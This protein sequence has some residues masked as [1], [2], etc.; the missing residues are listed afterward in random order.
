M[1]SK[2][3]SLQKFVQQEAE[4]NM[5]RAKCLSTTLKMNAMKQKLIY[6]NMENMELRKELKRIT[7]FSCVAKNEL[8]AIENYL[9]QLERKEFEVCG[10][11]DV[12][13]DY[14]LYEVWQTK[15]SFRPSLNMVLAP[16]QREG[17]RS[18]NGKGGSNKTNCFR[19]NEILKFRSHVASL[20]RKVWGATA[21]K[22]FKVVQE[23][24]IGIKQFFDAMLCIASINETV[25]RVL[26][27]FLGK[28]G[29][30]ETQY[31]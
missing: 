3:A 7:L 26:T 31:M 25:E 24:E 5:L 19:F 2:N 10:N 15:E 18:D 21:S 28:K 14:V 20:P 30:K 11:I 1:Y 12:S 23:R 17:T 13:R 9:E 16:I 22:S 8:N 6:R 4:I 29:F 27:D